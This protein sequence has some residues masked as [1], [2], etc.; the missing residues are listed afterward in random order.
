MFNRGMIKMKKILILVLL[1]VILISSCQ[2]QPKVTDVS[3]IA[4]SPDF[5]NELVE[6]CINKYVG[7]YRV[8]DCRDTVDGN[9]NLCDKLRTETEIQTCKGR[10]TGKLSYCDSLSGTELRTCY[11][12]V[13]KNMKPDPSQ[14]DEC[15]KIPGEYS[16][17]SRVT[18]KAIM[19]SDI[20]ECDLLEGTTSEFQIPHCAIEVA[21]ATHDPGI[22]V[23]I[24]SS[25]KDLCLQAVGGRNNDLEICK[26]IENPVKKASCE[27]YIT[28]KY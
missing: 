13:Y 16:E 6:F 4:D 8:G 27:D 26:Q 25:K 1:S 12:T 14:V 23:Q 24:D 28:R 21:V 18:C 19:L 10:I 3:E 5:F 22:C 20:T 17:S 15:E 7:V 11:T 9:F 2:T